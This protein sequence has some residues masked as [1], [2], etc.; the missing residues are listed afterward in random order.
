MLSF[1]GCFQFSAVLNTVCPCWGQSTALPATAPLRVGTDRPASR[2]P[3]P[4]SW[5]SFSYCIPPPPAPAIYGHRIRGSCA[6]VMLSLCVTVVVR[7]CEAPLSSSVLLFHPSSPSPFFLRF[8]CGFECVSSVDKTLCTVY[9][10][11]FSYHL[12]I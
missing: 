10:F 8:G 4:I 9:E 2:W 5:V 12:I 6:F 7:V 11:I 1:S 3:V